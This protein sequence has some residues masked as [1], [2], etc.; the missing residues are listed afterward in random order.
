MTSLA[1][2]SGSTGELCVTSAPFPTQTVFVASCILVAES[3]SITMLFPFVAFMVEDF[4]VCANAQDIGFYAGLVASSFSLAQLATSWI[5]GWTSDII[6]KRPILLTGLLGNMVFVIAFGMSNSLSMAIATRAL[7][8]ALNG[9]AGVA[10]AWVAQCT[11]PEHSARAFAIVSLTWGLGT[12]GGPACGGFLSQPADK[13]P[14][15]FAQDGI[16]GIYPYLLPCCVSAVITAVGFLMGVFTIQETSPRA[17]ARQKVKIKATEM[18][19][20]VRK[21]RLASDAQLQFKEQEFLGSLSVPASP[22]STTSSL[23][24]FHVSPPLLELSTRY[25]SM[26][27]YSVC[28]QPLAPVTSSRPSSSKSSP[29]FGSDRSSSLV[30]MPVG[31]PGAS[32]PLL[33]DG[34]SD[35]IVALNDGP[36]SGPRPTP[37][38]RSKVVV[39]SVLV[40]YFILANVQ[41]IFDEVFA[42]WALL[43]PSEGG[44]NFS[45]SNIG[46]AQTL[47]GFGL[48]LFQSTLHKKMTAIW[49]PLAMFRLC[50]GL[51]SA[52]FFFFPMAHGLACNPSRLS[53][54]CSPSLMW[55]TVVTVA[56]IR[57]S[58]GFACF[59]SMYV[60]INNSAPADQVGRINGFAQSVASGGRALGPWLGGTLFAWSNGPGHRFPFDYHFVY[61][62]IS[63]LA[64][65]A[66]AVAFTLPNSLDK[67]YDADRPEGPRKANTSEEESASLMMME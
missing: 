57:A 37:A 1:K 22:R 67:P 12:L 61:V 5:W 31:N 36:G 63:F 47:G 50:M 20:R 23:H 45:T 41:V 26:S 55:F 15:L 16:F 21:Y 52:F 30:K 44:L 64:L 8:G 46:L 53:D 40:V 59:V 48:L 28:V 58:L 25:S 34:D 29:S 9:N 42:L 2:K 17:L 11:P 56:I 60:I 66:T 13:Y 35:G 54:W 39:L 18:Q 14:L 43:H 3:F 4:G 7:T 49:G 51:S 27:K 24:S 6:G 38:H 10:K 62:F 33:H 65:F 32:V 19:N